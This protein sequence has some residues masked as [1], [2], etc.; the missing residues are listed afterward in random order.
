MRRDH[1]ADGR[2]GRRHA[3]RRR[4]RD[5]H[6]R[7]RGRG[8]AA[9]PA[10]ATTRSSARGAG[11]WSRSPPA[12]ASSTT[13]WPPSSPPSPS[14]TLLCGRYEGFDERVHEHLATDVVSIGPYV[15]AGGE[16]AAMVV[17]DAV[18]RKLPGRARPRATAPS[19]SRSARRSTARRSTRTTRGP[20]SGAGTGCRRCCSRATTRGSGSGGSS[21]AASAR[22]AAA[23]LSRP[24]ATI[25]R[26]ARGRPPA[27]APFFAMSGVIDS[28]ER[29]QLRRSRPSR[30]RPRAR[31]LP[32]RRGHPPPHPGLRG[33]RHQAP[34]QRRARDL[35]RPQA[36]LRRRRRA[37]VPACTRRR[38]SRSR[39]PAAATSRRAK[40]YYLRDRVGRRA[41]VRERRY[42][43]RRAVAG[44]ARC[45]RR[46]GRTTP[47]ARRRRRPPP[48]PRPRRRRRG[49]RGRRGDA[50]GDAARPQAG[51]EGRRGDCRGSDGAAP[52]PHAGR[53]RRGRGAAGRRRRRPSPTSPTQADGREPRRGRRWPA[54]REEQSASGSLI[55]LVI[56]VA[57]ALGLALGIQAFLVKP[58][59]IPS[60]SMVPDARGRPARARRPRLASASATPSAATSWSSSRRRAPT[61]TDCGVEPAAPDQAC[62]RADRRAVGHELHQAGRRPAGRPAQGRST[63]RVYI[64]GKLQDEPFIRPDASCGDL[65]PRRRRSRFRQ[66]HFFMMGDNRGRER[67]QPRVGT[68]PEGLDHRQRLLHLLAA[69]ARSGTLV[70]KRRRRSGRRLFAFDRALGRRFVAGA[71][72]AGRGCLA[73]PLVAAAVLFDLERL[74]LAD[75][76]AL[77]RLN[78]SKQHT[79]AAREELYPLVAAGR[80]RSRGR[81]RRCVRGIDARGLHVTNLEALRAAL[82]AVACRARSASSTASACRTSATSS[83]PW[84]TATATAPPSPRRRCWP[85]S[86]ATATCAAPPSGTPSWDFDTNVGYSTPEHRAAIAR[87]RHLAAAPAVVRVDRLPA[88]RA[89]RPDRG[90]RAS[91]RV[92]AACSRRQRAR[93]LAAERRRRSR[94]SGCSARC[95][96]PSRAALGQ[97]LRRHPPQL[98]RRLSRPDRVERRRAGPRRC[99]P[100]AS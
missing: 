19:R 41:R 49:G 77:A 52:R 75:R 17:C 10:T 54:A 28:L 27:L 55:E 7:R 97:P 58:F 65:Q 80:A 100:R 90:A 56:I 48:R 36:V 22:C 15:L 67:R 89:R 50:E 66:D 51:G 71:D 83:G 61:T 38:S 2:P 59:R 92:L 25:R 6:P 94:R 40:L 82:A 35:H 12:G 1:A 34:G 45:R 93:P 79:E 32:G 30:R 68:R 47:T 85:R 81:R 18:L 11:A 96:A 98:R 9:R 31:P 86:R 70:R 72:E 4:R 8:G 16:L 3:L 42:I 13:R 5:G 24:I 69:E 26:R 63:G 57:V 95:G 44:G 84:S 39:S 78:D 73:G 20:P 91:E 43:G 60:E 99:R 64:N 33:R 29:A 53:D 21:R 87:A 46:G 74:T 14:S 88:A 76:R 37:H 23:R 62:P